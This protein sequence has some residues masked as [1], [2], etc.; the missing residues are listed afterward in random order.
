[1]ILIRLLFGT[2]QTFFWEIATECFVLSSPLP[3]YFVFTN[4]L[5]GWILRTFFNPQ[6]PTVDFQCV[7]DWLS[8]S[9]IIWP[10]TKLMSFMLSGLLRSISFEALIWIKE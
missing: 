3:Y 7:D 2:I 5:S 1:M 8:S 9:S 10:R 4:C 6:Q